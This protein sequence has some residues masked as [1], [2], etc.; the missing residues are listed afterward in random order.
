MT[1]EKPPMRVWITGASSG[2]GAALAKSYSGSGAEVALTAR[3]RERLDECVA[4]LPIP[5]GSRSYPADVTNREE[6]SAAIS[7]IENAGPIDL[8]ILNAGTYAPT[9]LDHWN[10][11]A[12][13]D[14]FETNFFSV[15]TC[16]ELLLPYMRSRGHGHIAV[17]ASIAGDIGL[18]YAA[19]YSAS[20]AALNRVCQSLRPELEREGI[21][22][23]VINPGFVRTPLTARN[24]FPMPFLIDADRAAD[25]IRRDLERGRFDIRFPWRM[26]VAMRLLAALP[27]PLTLLLTRRMLRQ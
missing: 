20:K 11:N 6:L 26:S 18:P 3:S 4:A 21:A 16:I 1:D 8:A 13:R 24:T 10:T 14:L 5:A 17:V 27:A 7:G 25:I 15:T 9:D 23:S 22:I 19:P 2:L 12:I